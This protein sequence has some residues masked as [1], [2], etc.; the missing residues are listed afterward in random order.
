MWPWQQS[1]QSRFFK[2]YIKLLGLVLFLHILFLSFGLLVRDNSNLNQAVI[3][4]SN[5]VIRDLP[6]VFMP[7]YKNVPKKL[8]NFSKKTKIANKKAI[9]KKNSK[10]KLGLNKKILAKKNNIKKI[11]LKPKLSKKKILKKEVTKELN[12]LDKNIK[13]IS[14]KKL[15]K[16]KSK[17]IKL[18]NK[19][20][21]LSLKSKDISKK[22]IKSEVIKVG[23]KELAALQLQQI[24]QES[25]SETW[26]P[27]LGLDSDLEAIIEIDISWS[28]NLVDLIFNKES[29]VLAYDT[30]IRLAL[31]DIE[32]PKE[33]WG[34]KH[35]LIFKE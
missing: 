27:P 6:V 8:N 22:E 19:E 9:S 3:I 1:V 31:D 33:T 21:D 5:R 4:G 12:S 24:L 2:F 15:D 20:S 10:I 13:K 28:G 17:D 11:N 30:S 29:G 18:A 25:V 14:D 16:V 35:L 23:R 26:Q 7:I 34:K 32:W